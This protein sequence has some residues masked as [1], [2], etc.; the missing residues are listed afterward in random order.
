[1]N[2]LTAEK[3]KATERVRKLEAEREKLLKQVK[4]IT[5]IVQNVSDAVDIEGN[6]W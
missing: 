6:V 5:L 2:H 1:V 4:D 3:R